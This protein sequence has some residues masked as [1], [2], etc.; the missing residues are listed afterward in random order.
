MRGVDVGKEW[1]RRAP[2][3]DEDRKILFNQP[4]ARPAA[5]NFHGDYSEKAIAGTTMWASN[6]ICSQCARLIAHISGF[7]KCKIRKLGRNQQH[8]TG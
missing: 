7:V 4:P 6:P 3:S 2:P 1:R 5:G 8:A